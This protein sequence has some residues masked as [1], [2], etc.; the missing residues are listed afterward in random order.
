ML[1]CREDPDVP[2]IQCFMD[3]GTSPDFPSAWGKGEGGRMTEFSF[4]GEISFNWIGV[5]WFLDESI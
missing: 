1:F 5:T 4:L 2:M 3:Y